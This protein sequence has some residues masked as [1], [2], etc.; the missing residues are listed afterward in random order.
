MAMN[1]EEGDPPRRGETTTPGTPPGEAWERWGGSP[2][3]PYEESEERGEWGIGMEGFEPADE[4]GAD[5]RLPCGWL[6]SQV[7]DAEDRGVTD[8]HLHTCPHCTAARAELGVLGEAVREVIEEEEPDEGEFGDASEL[9]ERV[10]DMVRMELRPGRPLPLGEGDED[11]WIMET[12]A[13]KSVRRAVET[14]PGVQAGSCRMRPEEGGAGAEWPRSGGRETPREEPQRSERA[15][16]PRTWGRTHVQLEVVV[17]EAAPLWEIA[18]S[19]RTRVRSVMDHEL[20]LAVGA[21]DV[22]ITDIEA[23][24]ARDEGEGEIAMSARGAER[25]EPGTAQGGGR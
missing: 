8:P 11:L 5:E 4:K 16:G 15:A 21:V 24:D 25:D 20:G 14:V 9:A 3:A 1:G 2:L 18:D 19:I 7:W 17:S 12:A 10:M 23:G 13:A 6:L 22:R